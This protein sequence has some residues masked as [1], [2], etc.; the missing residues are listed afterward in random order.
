MNKCVFS[1]DL[2]IG[3]LGEDLTGIGREFQ[4]E[5]VEERNVLAYNTIRVENHHFQ[6]LKT[7]NTIKLTRC[8]YYERKHTV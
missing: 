5:A 7:I 4:R 1:L 6:T 3:R 8:D 2:K